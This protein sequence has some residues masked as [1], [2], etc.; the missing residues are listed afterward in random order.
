MLLARALELGPGVIDSN[1][2][3]VV[4]AAAGAAGQKI[5]LVHESLTERRQLHSLLEQRGY[6]VTD[7]DSVETA[8]QS[9]GQRKFDCVLIDMSAHGGD[10]YE[11]CRRM[12]ESLYGVDAVTV[13]M[14]TSHGSPFDRL[15][16]KMA[17]CDAY[18]TKPLDPHHLAEVLAQQGQTIPVRRINA[19]AEPVEPSR[20]GPLAGGSVQRRPR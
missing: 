19:A 7:A 12:K 6:A 16:G 20:P 9:I 4:A 11:G 5:L 13:V 18:L 1:V 10:A 14:L 3:P 8:L 2:S 15:R 17:G